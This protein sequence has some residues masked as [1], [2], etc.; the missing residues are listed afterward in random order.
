[1]KFDRL[2]AKSLPSDQDDRI[3][4]VFLPNHLRDVYAAA[5]Q[6]VACTGDDQLAALGLDARRWRSRLERVVTL[7]A[8]LHDLGK[9]ND[10]FQRM[11]RRRLP[12]K[13]GLRHEWL[14]VLMA[15]DEEFGLRE[16]LRF[17][18]M[19]GSGDDLDYFITLWAVSGHHPSYGRPSPPRFHVEGAGQ[20]LQICFG[21]RDLKSSLEWIGEQFGLSSPPDLDDFTLPLVGNRNAFQR[22][23]AFYRESVRRWQPLVDSQGG[24]QQETVRFVAAVKNCLVA[25]DIAGSA[26]P[27]EI[28]READRSKWIASGFERKPSGEEYR[29]I[30]GQRLGVAADKVDE[31]LYPFQRRVGVSDSRITFVKAGCGCGKTIAAYEWARRQCPG[32]RLYICYPTTGTATEGFRDYLVNEDVS[33]FHAKLF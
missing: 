29:T 13:Q 6:V 10:H 23:F 9:A 8:A 7:A 22:L 16:W 5:Q 12:H 26:L 33:Q 19:T 21:H 4:S 18:A 28:S 30:L 11:V 2:L 3:D 27:Q 20:Q 25:A 14:S 31:A 17:A 1:M 24:E 15:W 32:K